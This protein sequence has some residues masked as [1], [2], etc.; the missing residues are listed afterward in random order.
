M[1]VRAPQIS[2]GSRGSCPMRRA[3]TPPT[4][5]RRAN[6][7]EFTACDG[8]RRVLIH[9]A[10]R[11][12]SRSSEFRLSEVIA[13]DI[14]ILLMNLPR[15]DV[16]RV[17]ARYSRVFCRAHF[18]GHAGRIK[19]FGAEGRKPSNQRDARRISRWRRF[20]GISSIRMIHVRSHGSGRDSLSRALIASIIFE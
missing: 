11:V 9:V 15:K 10:S 7:A 14:S 18:S 20:E 8:I 13:F 2:G 19:V 16:P 3:T 6:A 17:I 12:A 5:S 1:P 4:F